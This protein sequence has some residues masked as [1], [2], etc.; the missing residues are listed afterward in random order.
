M[1]RTLSIAATA[2]ALLASPA[3][4]QDAPEKAPEP[5]AAAEVAAPEPALKVTGGV[6]LV[7]KYRFRGIGLSD[8]D[9][10]IQGTINLN[11]ES[12]FYAGLWSSSIDGFGELG[13]SNIELDLYAGYKKEIVSNLTLDVGVLY[14]AYPGSKGG[15]FEFFEPYANVSG[16]V[17]PGSFKVG[18]AF[19][20][21]DKGIGGNS[22]LYTF[23]DYALP[24]KGT[25][26]TL[27]SHLG[28]SKGK[29]TLTPGGDYLDWSLGA[30]ATWRNLTVGAAYVD[31]NISRSDAI[32]A[33]ATRKIVDGT[34]VLS[35]GA[36]F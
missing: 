14:Y 12:G 5:A 30:S 20:P 35:L 24:I 6:T 31:T 19:A 26:I 4:A 28:W 9:P 13:G 32:A 27:N 15:N 17:G 21:A 10:A 25:P 33:G 8:E 11:H 34:V 23:G 29:T 18:V 7:S 3:V 22:N 36:S 16:P 1:I 2:L